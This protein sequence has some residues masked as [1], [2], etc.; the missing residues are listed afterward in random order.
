MANDAIGAFAFLAFT[1][2]PDTIENELLFIKDVYNLELNADL[3]VLSACQTGIGKLQRGEGI[4]S[5]ARAFAYAGAKSIVTTLWN[6]NDVKTKDL[7]IDFHLKLK[8]GADKDVAL[9]QAQKKYL[10]THKGELANPYYWAPFISIGNKQ[11][12]K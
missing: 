7:M 9:F 5:L 10:E 8:N 1:E 4:I 6:V 12:I 2:I 3:V 11:G